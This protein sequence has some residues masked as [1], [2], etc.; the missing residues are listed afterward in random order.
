MARRLKNSGYKK[1]YKAQNKKVTILAD[2]IYSADEVEMLNRENT[3]PLIIRLD[4]EVYKSEANGNIYYLFSTLI[5]PIAL[6]DI[7]QFLS[8]NRK[9]VFLYNI[10]R[11]IFHIFGKKFD[12]ENSDLII[13]LEQQ[14]IT[15]LDLIS[16]VVERNL[17][18]SILIKKTNNC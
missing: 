8:R 17:D 7:N 4:K 9:A 14:A 18:A 3:F 13:Y 2:D 10:N 16:D 11:D 6:L 1:G 5:G 15:L 12:E